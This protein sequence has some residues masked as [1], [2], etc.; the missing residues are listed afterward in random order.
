MA[1]TFTQTPSRLTPANAEHIYTIES[2]LSDQ[3]NYK[4]VVNIIAFPYNWVDGETYII[5]KIKARPN[6]AGVLTFDAQKIIQSMLDPN[7]RVDWD[8]YLETDLKMYRGMIPQGGD[9]GEDSYYVSKPTLSEAFSRANANNNVEVFGP[10]EAEV[11]QEAKYHI[12]E[13]RIM[14]GE[15]YV[16]GI[17]NFVSNGPESDGA[18]FVAPP[19]DAYPSNVGAPSGSPYTNL[20]IAWEG[21]IGQYNQPLVYNDGVEVTYYDDIGGIIQQGQGTSDVAAYPITGGASTLPPP[22][23]GYVITVQ[24]NYTQKIWTFT[25]NPSESNTDGWVLTN[26]QYVLPYWFGQFMP[27]SVLTW[28]GA[29]DRLQES[30]WLP[31]TIPNEFN[32]NGHLYDSSRW[33]MHA[34]Q[35]DTVRSSS[36]GEF[37]NIAGP[38]VQID[39]TGEEIPTRT[40]TI[41]RGEPFM[42][43]FFNGFCLDFLNDLRC[44]V[45]R[46]HKKNQ[47]PGAFIWDIEYIIQNHGG[48]PLIN[49]DDPYPSFDVGDPIGDKLLH[50]TKNDIWAGWDPN[51]PIE[52]AE[53]YTWQY[54][55]DPTTNNPENIYES[56]SE[57]LRYEVKDVTCFNHPTYFVFLNRNGGWD[58]FTFGA[59]TVKSYDID[60]KT[61]TKSPYRNSSIYSKQSFDQAKVVYDTTITVGLTCE[62]EYLKQQDSVIVED[63]IRSSQVYIVEDIKVESP[64]QTVAPKLIPVTVQTNKVEEYEKRYEKLFQHTIEVEF[65]NI[66]GYNQS[67]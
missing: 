25:F 56:A 9:T 14:V 23:T 60:R 1:F 53:I 50:Y 18:K 35:S 49:P 16:D 52:W 4:Y 59:K 10:F 66:Q 22:Q 57:I 39:Y 51:N 63:L 54:E 27:E 55:Q 26:T 37:L 44:L 38:P 64:T 3:S 40:R 29:Q 7:I 6:S 45:F 15:E 20:Y 67:Q 5:A 33:Y 42:V 62:T 17:G 58:T 21:F 65:N 43:S 28:V 31:A 13:Y 48:G 11:G 19:E 36:F 32:I 8:D 47:A 2:D 34:K 12:M 30:R 61:Y 46:Y 41:Y 24:S